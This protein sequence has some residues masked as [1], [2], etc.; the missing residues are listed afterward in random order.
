MRIQTGSTATTEPLWPA[1]ITGIFG[2]SDSTAPVTGGYQI[3][4]RTSLDVESL[5]TGGGYVGWA[6]AYPGIGAPEDDADGD[7]VKNLMEYAT[8]SIPNNSA[9]L[10]Q[11][12]QTLIGP[13]LTATWAKG[14]A[15]ANDAALTWSIE[16]STSMAAGTWSTA[17][18]FLD[19]GATAISGDYI[20]TPAGPKAFL[21]LKVMR[22]P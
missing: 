17:G 5:G 12:V 11:S 18:V 22:T 16:A 8:G 3:L 1:N 14:A 2:Q 6:A 4:P 21:R 7:G 13:T 19:N 20:I 10:P 9:S 15:A